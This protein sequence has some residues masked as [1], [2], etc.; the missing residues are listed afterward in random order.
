MF[1]IGDRVILN[2]G[3]PTMEVVGISRNGRIWVEWSVDGDIE[4]HSFRP[5]MLSPVS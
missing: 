5:A 1:K 3:G 4:E 2:S